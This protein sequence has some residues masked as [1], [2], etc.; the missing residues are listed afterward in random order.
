M[1][2]ITHDSWEDINSLQWGRKRPITKATF[3]KRKKE[4]YRIVEEYIEKYPA[5]IIPFKKP[6][7]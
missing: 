3:E 4:G 6:V 1:E 5:K 7:S 2:M